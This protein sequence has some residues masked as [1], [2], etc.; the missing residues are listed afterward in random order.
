MKA[1]TDYPFVEL[2]DIPF[3]DADIREID[4]ISFDSNKYCKINYQNQPLEVKC[5]YLYTKP[6]RSGQVPCIDV[7][8]LPI[9]TSI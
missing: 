6:G 8:K 1:F 4:V 5:C 9:D 3:S 7:S 2:G